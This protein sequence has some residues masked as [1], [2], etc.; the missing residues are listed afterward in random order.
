MSRNT[1]SPA[2]TD[3][4]TNPKL[5]VALLA[6]ASA[7]ANDER[8][9]FNQKVADAYSRGACETEIVGAYADGGLRRLD[10]GLPVISFAWSG[11][12]H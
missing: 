5:R 3:P 7:A 9:T 2:D 12:T 6:V 10:H 4:T 8:Q 11:Q 1:A